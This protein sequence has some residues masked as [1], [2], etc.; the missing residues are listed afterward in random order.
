MTGMD[1]SAGL[2]DLADI[3]L[4]NLSVEAYLTAKPK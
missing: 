4:I 1:Q 3:L 2:R